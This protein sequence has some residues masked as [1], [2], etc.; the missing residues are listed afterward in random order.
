MTLQ[1]ELM[2][3]SKYYWGDIEWINL[4]KGVDPLTV[5]GI[6]A[7]LGSLYENYSNA[8]IEKI[9]MLAM[10]LLASSQFFL[11]DKDHLSI[12][13]NFIINSVAGLK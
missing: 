4:Y 11:E 7:Y 13:L 12:F 1:G 8:P 9:A 3:D 2:V 5:K 6:T 10:A